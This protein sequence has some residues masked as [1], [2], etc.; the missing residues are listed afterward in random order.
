MSEKKK[1]GSSGKE[2][3]NPEAVQ[4]ETVKADPS[5]EA[6]SREEAMA[7]FQLPAWAKRED[8]DKQFWK[9]G[10]I[11]KAQKDEQKLADIA[12]AYNI[13]T[14]DRDRQQEE[15]KEVETSKHYLGKTKKQWAEFWH[16]EWWKFALLAAVLIFG[17][18]FIRYYFLSPKT[19][20]RVAS[21][22]HFEQDTEVL[23]DYMKEHY[24]LTNP[25]VDFANVV[26]EN[27]EGE[28]IESYAAS[29]AT[30]LIAVRP[31][32]L[33]FDMMTAPAY[34]MGENLLNLDDI[35]AKM[36]A[37][38]PEEILAHYQPYI[39]SKA[40]FY[41][42]YAATMPEQYREELDEL[43]PEDYVDHVY[44]FIIS[45]PIDRLSLGYTVG[46]KKSDPSI[47]IGVNLASIQLEKAEDIFLRLL[48]DIEVFRGVY[49][50]S[51]PYAG[52]TD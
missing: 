35:Y 30:S 18:T 52:S 40:R 23:S 28:Q 44:G 29:K 22:G 51:H 2:K 32:I 5:I 25:D 48:S 11:Y 21:I 8:L 20:F 46:W 16:Y 42:D 9:L 33:V 7:Y 43:T 27:D 19:D 49:M 12:A 47:I 13:A 14:G 39:Y 26:S 45:D 37:E 15:K 24:D 6:M 36:Q 4:K 50:E 34:V 10:K 31:D 41:D 17:I 38:W 1:S 3:V